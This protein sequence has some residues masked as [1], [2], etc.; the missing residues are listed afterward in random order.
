MM[1]ACHLH[2]R[3]LFWSC[4]RCT[5]NAATFFT[6]HVRAFGT[7]HHRYLKHCFPRYVV[8]RGISRSVLRV[9]CGSVFISSRFCRWRVLTSCLTRSSQSRTKNPACALRMYHHASRFSRRSLC[10][11]RT[12]LEY[13]LPCSSRSDR[14]G[15]LLR[16]GAALLSIIFFSLLIS[17]PSVEFFVVPPEPAFDESSPC[18][19]SS[20]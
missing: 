3:I 6:H 14:Y 9:V 10:S 5:E 18:S 13:Q 15:L 20:F 17:A 7:S 4:C 16:L 19:R 11:G 1:S 8:V 2:L 12:V